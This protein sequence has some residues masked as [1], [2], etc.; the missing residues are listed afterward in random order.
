MPREHGESG[1]Y[2]E[3]VTLDAVRGVF[4]EVR[5]PVV[6]SADVADALGCSRETARR[7]LAALYDRGEVDRR[8]VSRR[9]LYWRA[10]SGARDAR[11]DAVEDRTDG[12]AAPPADGH[13]GHAPG[14][15]DV[16]DDALGS[17]EADTE[18][19]AETARA[20]TRRAAEYLA[21]TGGRLTRSALVDALA[22]ESSLGERTWWERAVQPG[23][24]YLA[25][26]DLVEYRAGHHDYRWVGPDTDGAPE[27]EDGGESGGGIYDPTEEF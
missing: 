26:A 25:E 17:W 10:E 13:G 15:V 19:N 8:K 22:A 20:Q 24:R 5:G 6:L 18:T 9:V 27:P 11:A 21:A 3:T 1:E 7:K 12:P 4:D 14:E 16:L 2:V 23:L